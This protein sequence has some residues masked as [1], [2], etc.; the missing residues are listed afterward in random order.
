MRVS[1]NEYSC[2]VYTGSKISFGDLTPYLTYAV[3]QDPRIRFASLQPIQIRIR[4]LPQVLNMWQN[5]RA[6]LKLTAVKFF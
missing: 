1:A 5:Q 6:F 2:T 4:I 3:D